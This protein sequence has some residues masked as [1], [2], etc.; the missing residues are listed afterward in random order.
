METRTARIRKLQKQIVAAKAEKEILEKYGAHK[1][2][3]QMQAHIDNLNSEL[4]QEKQ[5]ELREV[6]RPIIIPPAQKSWQANIGLFIVV[7]VIIAVI[8]YLIFYLITK[9]NLFLGS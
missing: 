5:L 1:P 2:A 9:T 7:G 3:L 6:S 8:A 4:E